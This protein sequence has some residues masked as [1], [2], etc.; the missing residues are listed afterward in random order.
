MKTVGIVL[1]TI[2]VLT[3]AAT[4]SAE[5]RSW[6]LGVGVLDGDFGVQTRKDFWL[7]GDISQI[8]GQ[9]SVY[10]HSKTTFRLDADY[11]FMIKAGDS[12]RFYPLAGLQF[13]F[14][15][16]NVELGINGG[17]GVNFM[18]TDKL[19]A[20]GEVKYVFGDWDGWAVTGG[21]YL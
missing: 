5:T 8:T 17:G 12:G 6:G 9:F 16:D 13:A 18:L 2:I 11:H 4:V 1:L 3:P 14:T 20:F 10:F 19:A 15:S 7:G 21:I